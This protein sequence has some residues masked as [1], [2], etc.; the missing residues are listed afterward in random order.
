MGNIGMPELAMIFLIALVLFGANRLPEI[1]KS[2]GKGIQEFKKAMN[3]VTL[4]SKP[5]GESKSEAPK[6]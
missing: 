4:D 2:L 3:E 6:V 5:T 1:G